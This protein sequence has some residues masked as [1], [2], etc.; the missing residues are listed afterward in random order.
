M[1]KIG[2]V[3]LPNVGKSTLF[4]ALTKKEVDIANYPFC[5]IEPNIGVVSVEDKRLNNL[6]KLF[7]TAKK[8]PAIVEFVDIAGLVKGASRGEGLGNKFLANIREVDAILE[9]VRVFENENIVHS[10]GKI[11]PKEDIEIIETELSLADLETVQKRIL[12]L[13]KEIKSKNNKEC[14]KEFEVLKKLE[15]SLAKGILIN[16]LDLTEEEKK[17]IKHL[18]LLTT[19]P[20]LYLFNYSN[21]I[22]ENIDFSKG[23]ENIF[24]D[25][26][27]ENEIVSLS[28]E[29][30]TE[31]GVN[32]EINKLIERSF[33]ILNLISFFTIGN[34]E[35]RAWEIEKGSKAPRAGRAIHT[36][37]EKKFIR[38]EVINWQNFLEIGSWQKAKEKGIIRSE[39]K[40]YLVQDGDIIQFLISN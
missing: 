1:L 15:K 34:D 2:I 30:Q 24:L 22:P 40:D 16:Y 23:R 17:L 11:D 31:L 20:I 38:A 9:V 21:K 3:G 4:K 13:E 33:K 25:V 28:K 5:T 6:Y 14:L 32:S 18:N 8:I 27:M 12:K 37:F 26:N 7:P 29:E 39:G 36:D 10:Q 35:V 19:K